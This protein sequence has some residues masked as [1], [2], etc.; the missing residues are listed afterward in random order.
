MMDMK[1]WL[2]KVV[3]GCPNLSPVR[4]GAMCRDGPRLNYCSF[5]RCHRKGD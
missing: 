5:Q 4:G 3:K 1:E 2:E